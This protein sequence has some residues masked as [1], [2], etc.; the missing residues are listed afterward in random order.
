MQSKENLS[1]DDTYQKILK[2]EKMT[3]ERLKTF[4]GFEV[5]NED[6]AKHIIETLE[7]YC[8][9]VVKQISKKKDYEGI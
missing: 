3:T 9:I 2:A 1:H 5:I 7:C 6:E 4:P 8:G